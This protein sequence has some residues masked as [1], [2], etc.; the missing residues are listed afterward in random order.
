M[1]EIL[2]F[3]FVPSVLSLFL[4]RNLVLG[5]SRA[6]VLSEDGVLYA[7]MDEDPTSCWTEL[8]KTLTKKGVEMCREWMFLCFCNSIIL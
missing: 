3:F 2:C 5:F 4:I 6:R 1:F 8:G 7:N